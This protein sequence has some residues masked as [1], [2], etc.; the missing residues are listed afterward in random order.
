[1]KFSLFVKSVGFSVLQNAGVPVTPE[2]VG[3]KVKNPTAVPGFAGMLGGNMHMPQPPQAPTEQEL[4]SDPQAQTRYNEALLT[5]N[6]QFQQFYQRAYWNMMRQFQQVQMRRAVSP[7]S[8][9]FGG[10][11][12]VGGILDASGEADG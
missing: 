3:I 10:N 8:P 4:A 5:Y 7:V 12:G 11:I 2:Q 9:G 1:M 6:R